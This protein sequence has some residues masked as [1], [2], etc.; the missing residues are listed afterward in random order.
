MLERSIVRRWLTWATVVALAFPA[1][2][3]D[4]FLRATGR[5]LSARERA[6]LEQRISELGSPDPGVRA[7]AVRRI[8]AIGRPAVPALLDVL[9]NA[10]DPKLVRNACLALGAIG[11]GTAL[12]LLEK[13]YLAQARPEEASRAALLALARGRSQTTSELAEQL[14]KLVVDAPLST[15]RECALLCA[16]ARRITGLRD[17]LK[18]PLVSERSARVRG[19]M[20]VALAEAGDPTAAPLIARFLDV[21]QTRDEKLRRAAL[22]AVA[23][24]GEPSLLAPL[25]KFEPDRREVAEYALALGTFQEPVVVEALGKLLLHERERALLAVHSLANIASPEAKGWLERALD[26]EFSETVR[27]G[28]ALV[29]ADLVDQQR[30]L[31]HLR[32]LAT[33]PAGLPSKASALLSLARIGD[34]ESATVIADALPLWRDRELI[35]RGLL[36]CATTLDRPAQELLPE[37]RRAT[38]PAL[39]EEVVGIEAKNL[40]SRLLRER[41][42][43]ALTA[44]RAHWL[45]ARDDLRV[46]VLRDLLELDRV[47]FA[48][49]RSDEVGNDG[50][51]PSPGS[52]SPPPAGGG[53]DGGDGGTGGGSSSE[54]PPP[55]RSNDQ[56]GG[57]VP[58]FGGRRGRQDTT[59]IELDLRAWLSDFQPF[60]VADPFSR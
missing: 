2:A 54:D 22:Y 8:D 40:D 23:R 46:G 41:I 1:V 12:A 37:A 35:E 7:R 51:V 43:A 56:Q 11:D 60:E 39:W 58:G 55:P 42:A 13:W 57:S 47:V 3:R 15:V 17:L 4:D 28:A 5:D 20:L 19:C 21:R 44:A 59:R 25:L 14:R 6:A 45:L 32:E 53:D 30:F 16:G 34:S 36:L 27:A 26:G 31:P 52:G 33:G 50:S 24:L 18:G 49:P 10:S 48:E 29:V 9:R 38:I